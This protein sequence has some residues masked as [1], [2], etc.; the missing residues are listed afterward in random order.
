M[1]AS[2][3]F[4]AFPLLIPLPFG[5]QTP[6]EGQAPELV[7]PRETPAA[8]PAESSAPAER[9]EPLPPPSYAAIV[10]GRYPRVG[11]EVIE[12]DGRLWV[13][14]SGSPELDEFRRQGEL[15]KHV[16]RPGAGPLGMTVGIWVFRLGD[17]AIDEFEQVGEPAKH[18]ILP[19]AGP[20]WMT[21]KGADRETIDAYLRCLPRRGGSV[22][23]CP[24][25]RRACGIVTGSRISTCRST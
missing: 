20:L 5:C 11:F 7:E 3:T 19:S 9:V 16:V 12:E 21:V 13:F 14:R 4:L 24:C 17:P 23:G 25:P 18:V 2:P 1:K 6:P 8:T 10:A 22:T 15:V